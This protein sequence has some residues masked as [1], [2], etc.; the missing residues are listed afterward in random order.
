MFCTTVLFVFT[1]NFNI[2]ALNFLIM[3]IWK[4]LAYQLITY[5]F[6]DM[7]M[8][9]RNFD[10]YRVISEKLG[11]LKAI[12]FYFKFYKREMEIAGLLQFSFLC[13][14]SGSS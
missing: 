12:K 10:N 13:F 7:K 6:V 8:A 14:R 11:N 4:L 1:Y 2:N 9:S 5:N 3:S